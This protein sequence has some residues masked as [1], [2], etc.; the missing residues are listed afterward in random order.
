MT[1]ACSP[2]QN[3]NTTIYPQPQPCP[4]CG[5]C[6]TC[7]RSGWNQWQYPTVTPQWQFPTVTCGSDTGGGIEY[8]AATTTA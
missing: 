7:G 8:R 6:P 1:D 3:L 2:S 4:H 5:R